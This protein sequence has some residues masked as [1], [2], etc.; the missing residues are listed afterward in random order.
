MALSHKKKNIYDQDLLAIA[1]ARTTT[2]IA[3]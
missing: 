3:A 1:A 2:A